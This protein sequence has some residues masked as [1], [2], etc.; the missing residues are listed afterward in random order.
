MVLTHAL[1]STGKNKTNVRGPIMPCERMRGWYVCLVCFFVLS[2]AITC[3][4]DPRP[5]SSARLTTH[6]HWSHERQHGIDHPAIIVEAPVLE[7]ECTDYSNVD[8][9][10]SSCTEGGQVDFFVS[11]RGLVPGFVYEFEIK[12][13]LDDTLTHTWKSVMENTEKDSYTLREPLM[14]RNDEFP[15][16]M[17]A[18]DAYKKGDDRFWIDVTVCDKY[19]GLT[20]EE[21]LI[22][23]RNMD[24]HVKTVRLKCVEYPSDFS[25]NTAS[26]ERAHMKQFLLEMQPQIPADRIVQDAR[27]LILSVHGGSAKVT[28]MQI[29]TAGVRRENIICV[30]WQHYTFVVDSAPCVRDAKLDALFISLVSKRSFALPECNLERFAQAAAD[31]L[32]QFDVLWADFP[33]VFALL[34]DR[35]APHKLIVRPT[36]RFDL[37]TT[38]LKANSTDYF[39]NNLL[40]VLRTAPVVF[41]GSEYDWWYIKYYSCREPKRLHVLWPTTFFESLGVPRRLTQ[42]S[43]FIMWGGSNHGGKGEANSSIRITFDEVQRLA[44]GRVSVKF[45][46][47]RFSH[48]SQFASEWG[49]LYFPYSMPSMAVHELYASGVPILAPSLQFM[50]AEFAAGKGYPH[51][52]AQY[53]PCSEP[54]FY[55]AAESSE[56]CCVP[57]D[58]SGCFDPNSCDPDALRQW[59][60]R[61][62]LYTTPHITYFDSAKDVVRI[63]EEWTRNPKQR[64]QVIEAML[65]HTVQAIKTSSATLQDAIR[66]IRDK[67]SGPASSLDETESQR[68]SAREWSLAACE[69]RLKYSYDF[70]V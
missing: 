66:T 62:D 15:F 31:A 7:C 49:I 70:L 55:A 6:E 45:R 65:S 36:H 48:V 11:M 13:T 39:H 24:S 18:W 52:T 63:M 44:R 58:S 3:E 22:G 23:T 14:Q 4:K 59:V 47:L 54:S 57:A 61:G 41:A 50:L 64:S 60:S 68:E 28:A 21:A 37:Y 10:A 29:Y 67:S 30:V 34:F 40:R 8:I 51:K 27:V 42:D 56:F 38:Y 46:P 5:I 1:R 32:A 25:A 69:L 53:R 20:T 9:E 35:V 26:R 16:G 43:A 2:V 17:M 19:P 33:V 12:W